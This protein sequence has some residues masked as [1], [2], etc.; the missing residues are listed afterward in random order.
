[1]ELEHQIT[2]P[3]PIQRWV[4]I[5]SDQEL[6]LLQHLI[7]DTMLFMITPTQKDPKRPAAL[8]AMLMTLL[9]TAAGTMLPSIPAS[10][11]ISGGLTGV[12]GEAPWG[13]ELRTSGGTPFCSGSLVGA[14]VVITAKHC[15]SGRS[16]S[17]LRVWIPGNGGMLRSVSAKHEANTVDI[18][19]LQLSSSA[20]GVGTVDVSRNPSTLSSF[21]GRGVTFFGWGRTSANSAM[22][23]RLRKTPNGSWVGAANCQ[24]FFGPEGTRACFL[25]TRT[26]AQDGV[27]LFG[28]DSGGAWVGWVNGRWVLMA[29]ERGGI[30]DVSPSSRGP[31]G[32]PSVASSRVHSWLVDNSWGAVTN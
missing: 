9:F 12:E 3:P 23:T 5:A 7:N 24:S 19:T 26:F 25:K 4:T 27:A 11:A 30:S 21:V 15:T 1:M 8:T 22:S 29:V 14:R 13:V 32:G 31:E 16:A 20:S 10:Q 6:R 18:A 17:S 2:K 28:G